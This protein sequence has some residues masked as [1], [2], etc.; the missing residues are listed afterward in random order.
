MHATPLT[1]YLTYQLYHARLLIQRIGPADPEPLHQFR[2]TLRRVRAL[3][4]LYF[5]DA[6]LF[7]KSLKG[8]IRQTNTLRELDVFVHS[9]DPERHKH[10]LKSLSRYR[11]DEYKALF[12]DEFTSSLYHLLDTLY[13]DLLRQNLFLDP[14]SMITVAQDHY[15]QSTFAYAEL[16]ADATPQER[17][18]LRI[19]FKISRYGL[20]FLNESGVKNEAE[21]ISECKRL[22]ARLGEMQDLFNQIEWLGEFC[23]DHPNPEFEELLRER[24][25]KLKKLTAATLSK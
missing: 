2:V 11:S 19:R 10:P 23:A 20:E 21:M 15:A 7:P 1:R 4:K 16:S 25:K 17:H 8:L 14:E 6:K 3:L 22:Q 9:L 18:K 13:D 24:K 12:A 5:P